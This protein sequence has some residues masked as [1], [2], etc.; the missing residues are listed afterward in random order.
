MWSTGRRQV[1]G[2]GV[3]IVTLGVV[4]AAG[5]VG[6]RGAYPADRPRLLSG[7][8]WLASTQ[9]GQLTLLDGSSA[10]VA[11]QVSIAPPGN[12]LDVAQQ[13]PVAYAV[14]RTAGSIRRVDGTTFEPTPAAAP[15]PDARDGLRAFAGTDV[16]YVLDTRRGV[17]TAADPHTLVTQGPPM[18]LTA[19]ISPQAATLDGAGRLWVLDPDSGDLVWL[20]DGQRHSRH[21]GTASAQ[22][23]VADGAPVLVDTTNHTATSFD[24]ASGAPRR[25]FPLDLRADDKV[26]AIGAAHD[27]RLYVVAARGVL[28]VCDLTGPG[29]GVTVP[30]GTRTSDFGAP[31]EA[32]GRVFVPDYATGQ[33]W[34]VDV[35]AGKVLARPRVL[36]PATRFQL[37]TR[38]GIVFFND[39]DSENAGVIRLDGGVTLVPKYD[40]GN[41]SRGLN[42]PGG[43]GGEN[44]TAGPDAPPD[45]PKQP[46]QPGPA[47][48]PTDPGTAPNQP[49][50]PPPPP[51]PPGAV[52]VSITVSS[53]TPLVGDTVTLAAV[54]PPGKPQPVDAEWD[55]ADGSH[56]SGTTVNHAWTAARTYQVTVTAVFA[57]RQTAKAFLTLR[58]ITRPVLTVQ[59]PGN[60]TVSGGGISCP[61]TCSAT[62]NPGQSVTLTATPAGGFIFLGWGGACGGTRTTC[63]LTMNGDK[64]VSASFGAPPRLTVTP[65]SNGTVSG[66]GINCPGTCTA[67]F[68]PGQSVTLTARPN[69][70]FSFLG[71]GGSCSGTRTTCTLTMNGDK[72]VSASFGARPRLTVEEPNGGTVS[73]GGINCPGTCTATF[74]PGQ[75]V[76]LTATPDAGLVFIGWGGACS[77]SARTCTL[78]MNGD[79]TVNADFGF[80]DPCPPVCFRSG[81]AGAAQPAAPTPQMSGALQAAAIARRQAVVRGRRASSR[82]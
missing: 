68:N 24:P 9:V 64:T 16:L 39:P 67:T 13:G 69:G 53:A 52:S 28:T 60:G 18:S 47:P 30:I 5:I 25:T 34:V 2:L 74:N 54:G 57:D 11:A 7:A 14:D 63:T 21:V 70:G 46:D 23:T 6:T 45:Q 12:Q 50:A 20:R 4:V 31:V 51:P 37:L 55:F 35:L 27:Q 1:G 76:T 36:N 72:N 19:R 38:D 75:R 17:L 48:T 15:L 61:G 80:A 78:T 59:P 49:P 77:G 56:G 42:N 44:G 29:C 73:G 10:E 40:P 82:R 65:P 3:G 22:L 26:Q 33:V 41:P 62:V 79:K 71:W 81:G 66:G 32:G 58:V 43:G 8:A